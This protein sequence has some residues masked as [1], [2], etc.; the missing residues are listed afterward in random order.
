M[1]RC[2]TWLVG[3]AMLLAT[4]VAARADTFVTGTVDFSGG[5]LIA[6]DARRANI[7]SAGVSYTNAWSTGPGGVPALGDKVTAVGFVK[8]SGAQVGVATSSATPD[9][10]VALYAIQG[11]IVD[12]NPATL[13]AAFTAGQVRVYDRGSGA[14]LL[15]NDPDTWLGAATPISAGALNSDLGRYDITNAPTAVVQ[16]LPGGTTTEA[17]VPFNLALINTSGVNLAAGVGSTT[18]EFVF[19]ENVDGSFTNDYNVGLINPDDILDDSP[20]G[21]IFVRL[22]QTLSSATGGLAPVGGT[23]DLNT[24]FTTFLGGTFDSGSGGGTYNPAAGLGPN[25][26]GDV[27]QQNDG[28]FVVPGGRPQQEEIPEPTSILLFSVIGIGGMAYRL[29]RRLRK[30]A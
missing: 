5:S 1:S 28:G 24:I 16:G 14:G 18:S 23:G 20:V 30:T 22:N 10:L 19:R 2:K 27:I 4:S 6:N 3:L 8:I 21:D 15:Q 29:R 25:G 13:R 11:T 12:A 9:R 17:L 7:D 26:N